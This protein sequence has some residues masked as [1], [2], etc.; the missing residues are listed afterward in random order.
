MLMP[1][2]HSSGKSS[3]TR[4]RK[5]HSGFTLIELMVGIAIGLLVVAVAMGALMAS[6]SITSTV[7]D[8]GQLQ[9]QASFAFRVFGQQIRQ[10][11]SIRLNLAANKAAGDPIN[12][13]D[14][15]AFSP[16]NV[17]YSADPNVVPSTPIVQGKDN[18]GTGEFKL[19][20][21]YQNYTEPNFP[22]GANVSTFRDC[23]GNQPSPTMIQ[24]QFVLDN[25]QLFCAGSDGVRQP[26]IRNV[27][28]FQV[29]YLTQTDALTGIP[30]INRLDAATAS[31]NWNQVFGV[32]ICLVIFGDD[33]I[34]LPSGTSYL[35]C[36][37]TTVHDMTTLAD[38]NRKNHV[39][40][41]FRHVYQIRS[42]GVAG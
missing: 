33:T 21:A 16:E 26:L 38:V 31:A 10:A 36:D 35:D 27:A 39:H 2:I 20:V 17:L 40:K 4:Q 24:S 22:S 34:S 12:A 5:F 7:S 13:E 41:I 1:A 3:P 11:G 9:Q 42:R 18:P 14:V 28:D 19:S 23:L 15:V 8:T 6:R 25:N 30:K 32:E 37:G 29:R